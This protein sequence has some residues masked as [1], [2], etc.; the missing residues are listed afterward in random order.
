MQGG[1]VV[2]PS[3]CVACGP[4]P[5]VV[6]LGEVGDLLQLGDAAALGGVGLQHVHRP[7][8]QSSGSELGAAEQVLPDRDRH[9]AA[10]PQLRQPGHVIGWVGFLQPGHLQVA[11]APAASAYKSTGS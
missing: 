4:K 9:R 1:G 10:P 3:P 11:S 6:H 8:G 5:Q 2:Q 7:R